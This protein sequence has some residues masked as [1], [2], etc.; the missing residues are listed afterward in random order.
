MDGPTRNGLP[1]RWI[2]DKLWSDAAATGADLLWRTKANHVL[3][4]ERVLGDGSF[5]STIYPSQKDRR[6][7]SSGVTVRVIEYRLGDTGSVTGEEMTYRLLTTILDPAAAP[8]DELAGCYRERWEIETAL[9]ELKTHQRS[10][11]VVLRSKMPDGVRQEAYA[12]LCVHYAIR[13]IMH[14]VASSA[15]E[16]PD[17]L[18]FTR[19][20]RVARRTTAS[21]PGFSP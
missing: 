12:Y 21:H 7:R 6:H 3:P 2:R 19:T 4:A 8:A 9:D 13:S 10:P 1:F 14:Q 20:L 15:R 17:R 11:R 18:S 16:D 5:L